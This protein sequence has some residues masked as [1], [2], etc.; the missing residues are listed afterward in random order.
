MNLQTQ[1]VN[2]SARPPGIDGLYWDID[3]ILVPFIETGELE[4]PSLPEAVVEVEKL[5]RKY[6]SGLN[7][8]QADM[9][10]QRCRN[11]IPA[12]VH[13]PTKFKFSDLESL[14]KEIAASV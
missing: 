14:F 13:G 4:L 10:A 12:F 2:F 8:M 1:N 3:S 9:F 6:E 5:L 7:D 11:L